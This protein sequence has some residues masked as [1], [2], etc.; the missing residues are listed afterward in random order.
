MGPWRKSLGARYGNGSSGCRG[1]DGRRRSDRPQT[2]RDPT[3]RFGC[4]RA[5]LRRILLS[6]R[7][8]L[9]RRRGVYGPVSRCPHHALHRAGRLGQDR[10]RSF[11]ARRA[12]L[13]S[14]R[15]QSLSNNVRQHLPLSSIAH[16]RLFRVGPERPHATKGR[17]RHDVQRPAGVP[18]RQ[19]WRDHVCGFRRLVASALFA[20]RSICSLGRLGACGRV[21]TA[22]RDCG[23]AERG[24]ASEP[25]IAPTRFSSISAIECRSG[26]RTARAPAQAALGRPK[27]DRHDFARCANVQIRLAEARCRL[28]ANDSDDAQLQ[29]IPT[30]VANWQS[31]PSGRRDRRSKLRPPHRPAWIRRHRLHHQSSCNGSP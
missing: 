6:E 21:A 16:S 10:R 15:R 13:C 5:S 4:L 29:S 9:R 3:Q 28:E 18:G 26:F 19:D 25:S 12:L 31:S 11:N 22:S 30:S 27:A 7:H 17:C 2:S 23:V 20:Q 24:S 14:A 8:K 1:D